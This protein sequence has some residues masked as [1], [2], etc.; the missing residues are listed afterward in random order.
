MY[1][2]KT[3]RVGKVEFI[4][5][6]DC[7]YHFRKAREDERAT[8]DQIINITANYGDVIPKQDYLDLKDTYSELQTKTEAKTTEMEKLKTE[9]E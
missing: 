8:T 3:T 1:K 7:L 6:H 5:I 4:Q 9:H 2:H